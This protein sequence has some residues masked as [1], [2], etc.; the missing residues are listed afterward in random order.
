MK[1]TALA[2]CLLVSSI[3]LAQ[4]DGVIFPQVYNFGYSVQVN[5]WNT[6]DQYVN[7]SGFLFMTTQNGFRDS[8]YYF[9][10]VPPRFNSFKQIYVRR[11]DDRIISVS[12]S[13]MCN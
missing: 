13:V 9:D 5:V 4:P 1:K 6:T 3:A 8:Q 10:Y 11:G 2:A 12:H 7:C